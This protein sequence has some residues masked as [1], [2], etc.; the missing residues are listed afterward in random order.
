MT[1]PSDKD[2]RQ[3]PDFTILF[4][5]VKESEDKLPELMAEVRRVNEEAEEIREL[6]RAVAEVSNQTPRTLTLS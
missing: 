1:G 6:R 5:K 4:Q 2:D 3:Q